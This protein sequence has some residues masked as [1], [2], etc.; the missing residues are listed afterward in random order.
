MSP[1]QRGA[2]GGKTEGDQMREGYRLLI[3]AQEGSAP[4]LSG[5]ALLL[6][7]LATSAACYAVL[8]FVR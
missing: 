1:G 7:W 4:S 8:S 3:V 6:C 2:L 5:F